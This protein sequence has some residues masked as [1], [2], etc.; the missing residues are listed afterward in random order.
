MRVKDAIGQFGEQ[1][2]AAHLE[3][4]GLTIIERNWRC[5]AGELDLIAREGREL[6]IVEVKTRSST[7][8]GSPAQAVDRA[9]IARIRRLT[10]LWLAEPE[11]QGDRS[12]TSI[13]FDVVSVLRHPSRGLTI[14]HLR[15][16]F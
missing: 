3:A 1:A 10:L 14:D 4:S 6:V 8:F 12:W 11:R 5:R 13:R 9:K 16:A 2:A 15:G 7:R